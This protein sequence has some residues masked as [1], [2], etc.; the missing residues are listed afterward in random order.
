MPEY[1]EF[2]EGIAAS[3]ARPSQVILNRSPEHAATVLAALF[4]HAHVCVY[5]VSSRLSPDVY[6]V[7]GVPEAA[8]TF[9]RENPEG[10]I[11]ILVE[12]EIDQVAHRFLAAIREQA[13]TRVNIAVIPENMKQRYSYNFA[14]AD[15][16]SYRFEENRDLRE[17]MIRFRD[18]DFGRKLDTAFRS[19]SAFA[20]QSIVE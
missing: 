19:L 18:P 5:I 10:K 11:R 14:L 2:V 12:N 17:A 9:L 3:G 15:G 20:G 6:C 13:A 4:R 7:D 16:E 8:A 1:S